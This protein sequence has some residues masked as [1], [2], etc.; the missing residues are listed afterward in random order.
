MEFLIFETLKK[1]TR[2]ILNKKK[3]LTKFP[4]NSAVEKNPKSTQI[5]KKKFVNHD[6][7]SKSTRVFAKIFLKSLSSLEW[8]IH[9]PNDI[10]LSVSQQQ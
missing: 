9:Y 7:S 3:K 5:I 4:E 8:K 1:F 6:F 10:L 2:Q